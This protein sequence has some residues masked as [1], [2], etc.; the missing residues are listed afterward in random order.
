MDNKVNIALPSEDLNETTYQAMEAAEKEEMHGP[1]KTVKDL[2]DDL[3][4]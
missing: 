4:S 1:F 2:M 3:N